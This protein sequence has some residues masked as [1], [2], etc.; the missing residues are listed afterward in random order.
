MLAAIRALTRASHPVYYRPMAHPE[1]LN[2]ITQIS[3]AQLRDDLTTFIDRVA[4][5]ED[6]LVVTRGG[7][8]IAAVISMEGW[9]ALRHVAEGVVERLL[10]EDRLRALPGN[11]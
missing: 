4:F 3:E 1:I 9:R 7:Q 6:E 5:A 11:S 10:G 2:D 8:P